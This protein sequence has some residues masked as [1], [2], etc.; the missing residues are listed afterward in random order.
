MEFKVCGLKIHLFK[1]LEVF[2]GNL[3]NNEDSNC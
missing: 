1:F 3:D 2:L